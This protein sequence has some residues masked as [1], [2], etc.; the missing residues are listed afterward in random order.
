MDDKLR[1]LFSMSIMLN[2]ESFP[3]GINVHRNSDLSLEQFVSIR[4]KNSGNIT[5]TL[6]KAN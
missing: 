6:G 4:L 2:A 3:C 5:S 1:N